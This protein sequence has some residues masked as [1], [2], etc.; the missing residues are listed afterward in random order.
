MALELDPFVTIT[1]GLE[2]VYATVAG[3]FPTILFV[4]ITLFVAYIVINIIQRV[5]KKFFD[6]VDFN[7]DLE[8]LA[9]RGIGWVSWFFVLIWLVGQ[10]GQEEIFAA[11]I[12]GGTLAGLAIALAVKDS[13]A[14]VVGG[15][16]LLQDKHFDLGDKIKTV[17]TEGKI[18]EVGL[19]KTRMQLDN[20][21]MQIIPNAKIDKS[22][23]VLLP[24]K[25]ER[26]R[27]FTKLSKRAKKVAV[28]KKK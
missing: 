15:V 11:L 13:L 1:A 12:A 26:E 10:L 8:Y 21:E 27:L 2:K 16:L 5:A 4:G 25:K 17:G 23:W 28:R 9:Y 7:P 22:G 24:R 6:K 18:V 20:G 19:R 3:A 14:D